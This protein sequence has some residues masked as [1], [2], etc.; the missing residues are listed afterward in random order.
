M[1]STFGDTLK[2]SPNYEFSLEQ[3]A[4]K[5]E[6]IQLTNPGAIP[7]TA[8][9][10]VINPHPDLI[11]VTLSQP[12]PT[13]AAGET[14]TLPIVIRARTTTP[15]GAYDDLL[16]KITIDDGSTLYASLKVYVTPAG[17]GQLPDL[18]ITANDIRSTTNPDGTVTLTADIRNS[19]L[20]LAENV[21][22]QFYEFGNP[23]GAPVTVAQIASNGIGTASNTASAL[24]AGDHLIRVVVDPTNEIT[25]LD[26]TNN[27]ASRLITIGSSGPPTEG[28]ILV[29]GSLPA[30][31]YTDSLFTLNG[32]AVYDLYVNGTRIT[33]YVVK[34]GS[35]QIT[36]KAEGGTESWV[37]GDVY[38]DV[39]GNFSKVLQAPTTPGTYRIVM[40]VTDKTF[41]GTRELFF[42]TINAP[43]TPPAPPSPPPLPSGD[44]PAGS[45]GPGSA[46][47]D[48][49]WIPQSGSGPAPTSDLWVFSKNIYF[50]KNNPAADEEITVFAQIFYW[51]PS[52]ALV[53][54]NVPINVYA[55]YPGSAK[56]KIGQTLIPSLRVGSPDYGSRY[57]YAT[58]KN[59]GDGIY[60]IEF[61]IDPS[62]AETNQLNNAATRAIIAGQ[63]SG[64]TSGV[65]SGQV[66]DSSGGVGNVMIHVL[67]TNGAQIGNAITDATGFYLVGNLPLDTL[68]VR[69]VTPSGYVPDAETKTASVTGQA[70]STVDFRL[71]TQP[72]DTTP[73]VITPTVTGTLG[74]NDWYT[75]DVTVSWYVTDPESTVNSKSGCEPSTV[76]ADT[77]GVPF[78]C[79]ATS[80]G[81]T[82]EKSVT[83]KRD[84]TLPTIAGSASPAANA[85]GWRNDPVTVSFTCNDAG[86]GIA[87]C[88]DPQ[89]LGN[90]GANQTA[91]GTATDKAGNTASASVTGISIDRTPPTVSVTGVA[92]G[93]SYPLGSVPTAG[94]STT[95]ALS[96]VQT[97]AALSVTGGNPSGSGTFTASCAGVTDKAGN[98]G[99]TASATYQVY[100]ADTTPPVIAPIVN[101]TP[102]NNGWYV[103]NVS[104]GWTATDGESAITARNGCDTATVATDTAGITF[105]CSATSG[106]GTASNSV[107]VKRD[108]T[109]PAV[110]VTGVASGATYPLG[111]V[112]TAGC[113]TTDALSGVQTQAA[114]S[115]TGGNPS[116]SGTF[117]A[118]CA[119]AL[120][121]AGNAGATASATYTVTDTPP[122]ASAFSAF[123]VNP[124]RINQ[125]LKTFFL[126]S[127]FTL[128]ANSNGINPVAETVTLKIAGLTTTI[129]AGSFR[130]GRLGAYAFAGKIDNV[131]IEALITPLGN[132]RFGFQAGAYG[133]N[134]S[135]A[136]NPVTVGL[137]IGND[138]GE[139]SVNASIIK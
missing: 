62:Y 135:V 137:V 58:W 42:N 28:S 34:G 47:G 97:Q 37:Y 91:N 73:P 109:P 10:E 129:P 72:E 85:N 96:G 122:S 70:V 51:A 139:I 67:D 52:T 24:T 20:A 111:S 108:A 35:V 64:N 93:A 121:N 3:G 22:V 95:D 74:Q 29:T 89:T 107:T 14:Q 126:L 49:I 38:T 8:T 75:S 30:T 69:I 76:S 45:W 53:A 68:Q 77:A 125:R 60:L 86:S 66:V 18:A 94:C 105:T 131:W 43:A 16:L 136:A 7:Q 92:D 80:S 5:T 104:V 132:N 13:I 2:L 87:T 78:T 26:E 15:T 21:Q 50:S 12:S 54:R 48:F 41:V 23:L 88:P 100:A 9:L 19:G 83:I 133:T 112:P 130:K 117:T 40:T 118:S 128:G 4:Q 103:G 59:Q 138:S 44:T 56:V 127:T 27:E 32:R 55:T 102:G 81:G 119:G 134:L 1:V 110:S 116:G 31:I 39:D 79:S 82:A 25:E 120:D 115:V 46:P 61:E 123:S 63:V 71:T 65:I 101:G 106:G 113:A 33:D 98:A 99:A 57:V 90:E 11:T 36:V 6:S 84:A 114:L 124:L 17:A